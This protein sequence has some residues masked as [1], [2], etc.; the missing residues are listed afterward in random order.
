VIG[1]AQ[2]Q[3]HLPEQVGTAVAFAA[4]IAQ[5]LDR[6]ETRTSERSALTALA[7]TVE[8]LQR[9]LLSEPPEP[10]HLQVSVRYLPAARQAQ[11]GGD[12]YD[13]F[14]LADGRTALVIGDVTGH[15]SLAAAAMAQVR[16]VLRGVA[17]SGGG[18]PAQ[19][20]SGLDLAMRDLA[21]G[22]LATA[23]LATVEQ[24][25]G[26]RVLRWSNAGHPAPLLVRPD[27]SVEVLERR[28]DLLLGVDPGAR[29]A[30]H[31][32]LLEPGSTVLLYTDG[33]IERPGVPLD[34]GEAWLVGL[35]QGIGQ[36]PLE[37]LCD[38]VL[39]ELAGRVD[40]DVALL[41]IRAHR[42]DRPRPA[43]AGPVQLPEGHSALR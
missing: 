21:I 42:E 38:R 15:D 36:L 43:E 17:H 25:D 26:G 16:N 19:V 7:G 24:V 27:G 32:H 30:D 31:L 37:E 18:T 11:V 14:V 8:A 29:R 12:W 13:S 22:T 20:L 34:E 5:A 33:L 41:A 2:P 28:A 39:G 40:D 23:V 4:Q 9:S 3:A 35:L 1:W 10:D 6:L